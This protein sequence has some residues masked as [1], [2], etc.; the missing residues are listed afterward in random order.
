MD[1]IN[2]QQLNPEIRNK[3]NSI[4]N[5]SNL[6]TNY[7]EDLVGAINEVNENVNNH[8]HDASDI[9]SGI[10][11][12]ARIP[13]LEGSKIISSVNH[14]KN[15]DKIGGMTAEDIMEKIYTIGRSMPIAVP[16]NTLQESFDTTRRLGFENYSLLVA[17]HMPKAIGEIRISLE[18]RGYLSGANP[19]NSIAVI[20]SSADYAITSVD[21]RTPVGT[22]DVADIYPGMTLVTQS[23]NSSWRTVDKVLRITTLVPIYI[24]MTLVPYSLEEAFIECRNIRF[25]YDII[26]GD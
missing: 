15:A 22:F 7:K 16:S 10:F 18:H 21:W 5:K 26:R 19:Y 1:K 13:D 3:L 14:A 6:S 20:P 8:T 4:G 9:T 2:M 12:V 25:Y 17:K 11:D 23:R 24:V